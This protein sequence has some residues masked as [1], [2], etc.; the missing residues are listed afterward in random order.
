MK[1]NELQLFQETTS[2]IAGICHCSSLSPIICTFGFLYFVSIHLHPCSTLHEQFSFDKTSGPTSRATSSEI[3][4]QLAHQQDRSFCINQEHQVD[5]D[6]GEIIIFIARI[7]FFSFGKHFSFL[8]LMSH[9][10]LHYL[11]SAD[12]SKS[13]FQVMSIIFSQYFLQQILPSEKVSGYPTLVILCFINFKSSCYKGLGTSITVENIF[14]S[15]LQYTKLHNG[16]ALRPN[17][18]RIQLI[19]KGV[20][21]FEPWF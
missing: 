20:K 17:Q 15:S 10:I 13:F 19:L 16:L 21:F 7:Q 9:G 5:Y 18:R 2:V 1:R 8:K 4:I 6:S 3:L 14:S 11:Q 12:L